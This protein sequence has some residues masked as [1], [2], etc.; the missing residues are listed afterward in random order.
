MNPM[1]AVVLWPADLTDLEGICYGWKQPLVCVAGVIAT[2]DSA[3]AERMVTLASLRS[4]WSA[5]RQMFSSDPVVLGHCRSR[6]SEGRSLEFSFLDDSQNLEVGQLLVYRRHK[7]SSMRFYSFNFS[8]L[9]ILPSQ[10]S[11]GSDT[12]NVAALAN[13]SLAADFTRLGSS[14][15]RK[16]A[17]FD[18]EV[19]SQ[20]NLAHLLAAI[21]EKEA[22]SSDAPSNPSAGAPEP[23]GR[24][25]SPPPSRT[26][27]ITPSSLANIIATIYGVS[28]QISSTMEQCDIR[29][30]QG[31]YVSREVSYVY[32]DKA[33]TVHSI[34]KYIKFHNCVWLVLNDVIIGVAFGSFLC[35]NKQFFA[36]WLH[37][38]LQTYLIDGMRE[39][40]LWLNSWPAGLKLNTELSQFYCHS[41][42]GLVSVWGW[43]LEHAAPYFPALVWL[44]GVGGCC[45]MTMIV[46]LLS[47]SLSLLMAHL[48]VCYYLSATVFSHQLGLAGSLWN[49]FRGKRYNV[50][51]N[52]IDSWDYDMDQLLLGT[53]LFTLLAFLLPT[54][55]T[56]YALFATAR[57]SVIIV[58]A[59]FDTITALLNHFPLFALLLRLKDP[60][61]LPGGVFIQRSKTGP[62]LLSSQPAPLSS[63]FRHYAHLARRLIT[64]YHPLRMLRQLASG[65][66]LSPISRE[67]IRYSMVPTEDVLKR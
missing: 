62:L 41:L 21:V 56:Y 8:E 31:L 59:M 7:R 64:H 12:R 16:G 42:I 2:T 5:V 4:E 3:E 6:S 35:E 63:I 45:G 33:R 58:H 50:L 48:Y 11:E 9:D 29:Y 51:R 55:L 26:T 37:Y 44:I 17:V 46:S 66:P 23:T 1:S 39:A 65:R 57:L 22:T 60:L 40:L 15:K 25:E 20:A 34:S 53:I 19:L 27:P 61:R 18:A 47:D 13:E 30:E 49:L 10:E 14:P 32:Q 38:G 54:V 28:R 24:G 43:L 36:Q 52:R 67:A